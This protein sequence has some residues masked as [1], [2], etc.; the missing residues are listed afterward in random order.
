M[1]MMPPRPPPPGIGMPS[2]RR[3][4]P[5][6]PPSL[7]REVS[8]S[9]RSLSSIVTRSPYA[10]EFLLCVVSSIEC[11]PGSGQAFRTR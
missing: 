2:R 7:S 9:A 1:P 10:G 5:P 11:R 4:P 3:T 6:P 8:I